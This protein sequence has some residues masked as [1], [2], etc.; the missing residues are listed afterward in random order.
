MTPSAD[1]RRAPRLYDTLRNPLAHSLAVQTQEIKARQG[2]PKHVIV[3]KPS[4][5]SFGIGKPRLPQDLLEQMERSPRR[6]HQH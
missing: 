5:I 2:Q 3:K 1:A 6:P 4:G